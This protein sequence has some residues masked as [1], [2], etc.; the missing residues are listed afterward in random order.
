MVLYRKAKFTQTFRHY[1]WTDGL[2]KWIMHP[3]YKD[4]VKHL[5]RVCHLVSEIIGSTLLCILL[6]VI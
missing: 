6:P 1:R 2:R 5:T 4:V 3:V